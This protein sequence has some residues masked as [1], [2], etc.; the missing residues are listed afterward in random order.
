M[1][2]IKYCI[3]TYSI[4]FVCLKKDTVSVSVSKFL[5]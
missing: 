2:T 4:S 3:N 1:L 5:K